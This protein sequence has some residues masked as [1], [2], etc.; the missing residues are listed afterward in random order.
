MVSHDIFN[1]NGHVASALT[2]AL[3]ASLALT[4][5][6]SNVGGTP[7]RAEVLSSAEDNSITPQAVPSY[8][9]PIVPP[10]EGSEALPDDCEGDSVITKEEQDEILAGYIPEHVLRD[11]AVEGVVQKV[12]VYVAVDEQIDPEKYNFDKPLNVVYVLLDYLTQDV[13]KG[14]EVPIEAFLARKP[15][16]NNGEPFPGGTIL[17]AVRDQRCLPD[18]GSGE[19]TGV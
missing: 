8:E 4:G 6:G 12:E 3:L 19:G 13:K 2:G 16:Q 9:E 7:L 5:C 14:G 1:G 10:S 17:V 18:N 15:L 11:L